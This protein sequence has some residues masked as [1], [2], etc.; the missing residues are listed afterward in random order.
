MCLRFHLHRKF[1]HS[2]VS[3]V[4]DNIA[5]G[6]VFDD[7]IAVIHWNTE[8]TSTN[9]YSSIAAIEKIHGHN[10]NTEIIFDDS[11]IKEEEIKKDGQ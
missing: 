2:G 3:G 4:S 6:V 7:G 1:D 10:G 5:E 8:D 9:I 11:P